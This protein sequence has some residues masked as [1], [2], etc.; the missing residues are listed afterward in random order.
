MSLMSPAEV[1]QYYC[2]AGK[3]KADRTLGKMFALAIFAGFIIAMA[4]VFSNTSAHGI[5]EVGAQRMV[6]G[7][8]FAFGLPMVILLGAELFTGN[9]MICMTVASR[10]TTIVK[11]LRNWFFVYVGNFV[12]GLMVAAGCAFFGQFKYSDG[13]LAVYT[14]KAAV[15]KLSL[16]FGNAI[17]MGILCNILVCMAVLAS[18]AA[19][20]SVGRILGAY[21]PVALF[22]A[23][24]FEHSIANM[25]NIPAAI[26]ANM[27][28]TYAALAVEAGVD[29]SVLTVGNL[30]T[31][32]LIPVTI[33]NII[34]GL[35]LGMLMWCTMLKPSKNKV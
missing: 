28:P 30:F 34:G 20:D 22:A 7:L 17:V 18:L 10:K 11:M 33:G 3:V 13:Q 1:T 6:S 8:T 35:I 19:K 9:V 26:F 4:A 5:D 27:N 2:D 14:M 16:P 15:S 32:N 21:I 31:A 23:V 29:T 24:G 25:Y 12:G